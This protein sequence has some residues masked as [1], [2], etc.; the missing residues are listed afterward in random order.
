VLLFVDTSVWV[1]FF[2]G[3]E[4]EVRRLSDFLDEGRVALAAP[5]RV[6]L[7]SG[8]SKNDFRR[9]QRTLSA[10]PV[11]FP[12]EATFRL[13]ETWLERAVA[14]GERFGAVDLLIAAIAQEREGRLWSLDADFKR[15]ARLGFVDALP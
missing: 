4:P 6:E 5:V 7:L 15:M 2:R 13:I 8:A 9:L 1:N 10:L 12:S 3:R 11:F 14:G